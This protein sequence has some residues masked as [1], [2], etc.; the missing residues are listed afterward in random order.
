MSWNINIP[1]SGGKLDVNEI[2]VSG[3]L[4]ADT[5]IKLFGHEATGIGGVDSVGVSVDGFAASA[6]KPET[7][8]RV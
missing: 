8:S 6:S 4:P 3:T 5:V 2:T 7:V 1:V